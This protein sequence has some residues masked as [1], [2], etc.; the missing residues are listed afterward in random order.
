MTGIM[1]AFIRPTE[2]TN[3]H[4]YSLCIHIFFRIVLDTHLGNGRNCT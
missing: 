2:Y 4:F 3:T 1:D